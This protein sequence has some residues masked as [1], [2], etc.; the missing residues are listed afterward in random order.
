MKHLVK[1]YSGHDFTAQHPKAFLS[2]FQFLVWGLWFPLGLIFLIKKREKYLFFFKA[3]Q[4][5]AHVQRVASSAATL[6]KFQEHPAL[7]W[8]GEQGTG[9]SRGGHGPKQELPLKSGHMNLRAQALGHVLEL[10][11]GRVRSSGD[12]CSWDF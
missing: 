7:R 4:F 9:M 10:N 5:P 1:S 11:S 8:G 2:L 6:A 12:G 3:A